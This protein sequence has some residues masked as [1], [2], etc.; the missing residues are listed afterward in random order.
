V[1]LPERWRQALGAFH[2]LTDPHHPAMAKAAAP[3]GKKDTGE[4]TQLILR[5]KKL[6]HDYA[7]LDSWEAGMVLMGSE[8]KSLRAG[9]V[10][11]ADAHARL[12][13]NNELWLYGLH[14][15]EYRQA[16]VFGH[17][18]QQPRKLLLKR[19][20]LDK[21]VGLMKGKGLTLAPEA[22][23]FRHGYAKC[24]VCLCQGKTRG[25]KRQDLI[26][27]AQKRDV[28]REMARRLKRG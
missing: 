6:R 21:I 3:K 16:G 20:E 28:D 24:V 12:D 25:D 23:F 14:I 5:N 4:E 8:V 9:D 13:K 10:Q 22:M 7:V 19:R 2:P 18:P 17:V 1:G 27:T 11:I 15:G 26:K